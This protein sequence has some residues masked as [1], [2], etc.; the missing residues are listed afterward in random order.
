MAIYNSSVAV[1]LIVEMFCRTA[2]N[3]DYHDLTDRVNQVIYGQDDIIDHLKNG[4]SGNGD[5]N[6]DS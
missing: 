1:Y 4:A 3:L 5:G 6:G 2:I